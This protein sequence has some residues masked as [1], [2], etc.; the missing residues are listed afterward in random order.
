MSKNLKMVF[1]ISLSYY[2]TLADFCQPLITSPSPPISCPVKRRLYALALFHYIS[3]YAL[4]GEFENENE[5]RDLKFYRF[6]SIICY[7]LI[8]S[9]EKD[10]ETTNE[11]YKDE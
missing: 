1:L 4:Q 9:R 7:N 6:L 11:V 3:L 5:M 2:R 10:T 8:R